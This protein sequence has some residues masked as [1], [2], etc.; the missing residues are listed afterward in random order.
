MRPI[1]A[2]F[3]QISYDS[4]HSGRNYP[5]KAEHLQTN[6]RLDTG[7]PPPAICSRVYP[8]LRGGTGSGGIEIVLWLG[9]S[10]LA[11]G[12]PRAPRPYPRCGGSIP[13]CAGEPQPEPATA[14]PFGVYPRL[15]GGTQLITGEA[16]RGGG[17]SPLARGNPLS[18]RQ[19]CGVVGSIPACAG[20]PRSGCRQ[21]FC[22][23][24][25]PRLRGGTVRRKLQRIDD[26]GL[27]PLA[28]GNQAALQPRHFQIGSI[29]ACAGEPPLRRSG[30][31]RSRVYPRL[32]G[33]VLIYT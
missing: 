18:M 12:N 10:P 16:K 20:E 15:R 2:I 17:L 19:S 9:L 11:R 1:R 31:K 22:A 29:P 6:Q 26:R 27:S 32:R 30:A 28:R 14:A 33:G 23:R 4:A 24:V 5:V 13:A 25:Y 7:W 3:R 21:R 8:R